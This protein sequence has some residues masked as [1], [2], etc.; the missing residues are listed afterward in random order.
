MCRSLDQSK[1]HG[2]AKL[3]RDLQDTHEFSVSLLL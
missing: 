3:Q 2:T 1:I